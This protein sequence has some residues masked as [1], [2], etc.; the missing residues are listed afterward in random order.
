MGLK[1]NQ[2]ACALKT[3]AGCLDLVKD[4][5]PHMIITSGF[6]RPGDVANSSKTS[7]HYNGEA[8]DVQL[9][10]Y[11]RKEYKEAVKKITQMFPF[12]QVILEYQGNTTWI[13]IGVS[14]SS[15]RGQIFTMNNHK[16]IGEMGELVVLA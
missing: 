12:D 8:A 16:R 1:P 13:H 14:K 15:Q 10:G 3:L 7:K 2:I 6:R 5:F 9:P 11:S 4:M